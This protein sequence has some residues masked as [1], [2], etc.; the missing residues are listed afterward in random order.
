MGDMKTRE[1]EPAESQPAEAGRPAAAPAG[2]FSM[3]AIREAVARARG[4]DRAAVA[5]LRQ[6]TAS[7]GSV[8]ASA[9]AAAPCVL[10][11]TTVVP[12]DGDLSDDEAL[13]ATRNL[14]APVQ[15]GNGGF[16]LSTDC[17]RREFMRWARE[18][19]GT[20][21]AAIAHFSAIEA[22]G[23]PGSPL[24]HHDTRVR[25][26]AVAAE[27][28][29][30]MPST[31]VAFSF[32]GTFTGKH[33]APTSMHT[34]GYALDYDAVGMPQMGSS[35]MALLIELMTGGPANAQILDYSRRRDAIRRMG[36]RTAASQA[37]TAGDANAA[38]VLS[39][40]TTELARISAASTAFQTIL[41]ATA[42]AQF[43]ELR[44][45]YFEADAAARPALLAQVA[46]LLAPFE[47]AIAAAEGVADVSA[48]R[49]ALLASLRAKLRDPQFLFGAAL[50]PRAPRPPRRARGEP[51]PPVQ[52]APRP[53][54]RHVVSSPSLAQLFERGWFTPGTGGER[55]GVDFALSMAR[56]GFEGGYVWGGESQDSM[57]FELVVARP[58]RPPAATSRP[59]SRAAAAHDDEHAAA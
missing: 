30:A 50:R 54:T 5:L 2:G 23:V 58:F 7:G 17:R 43:L 20:Y 22:A 12:V 51:E 37:P 47:T 1:A 32:R 29:S 6:V 15:N 34:L 38:S 11:D 24:V 21:R 57:H 46:P 33:P 3:A 9:Q 45:Q 40:I 25:L 4:G 27:L 48:G 36:D 42:R 18:W 56:H 44:T 19:F 55:W 31:T 14:P 16:A 59:A 28:G 49:R 8:A 41:G 52:P 39:G 10:T 35:E 26:E 13:E 53:T